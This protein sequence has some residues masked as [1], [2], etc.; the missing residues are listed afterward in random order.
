ME[1][2]TTANVL[3]WLFVTLGFFLMFVSYWVAS[4]ALF[5]AQVEKC[6]RHFGKPVVT[7]LFGLLVFTLPLAAGIVVSNVAPPA[8]KWIG[9]LMIALPIL[10]GLVGSAGL[11]RRIGSG[12]PAPPDATQPWRRVLRGGVV[13]A[14][15]F[16]LPL[17]GQF[18]VMPLVL[19]AGSGAAVISWFA[20][21]APA[22][23]PAPEPLPSPPP[24]G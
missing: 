7:T 14:L 13:L 19:A 16:L 22:G 4:A 20:R 15:T 21:S 11:A 24:L 9:V 18:V 6:E 8:L 3:V 10:L 12:L 1:Y 17:I 2:I 23:V 5:P